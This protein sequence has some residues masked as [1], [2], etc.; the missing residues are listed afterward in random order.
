M[1]D[2]H[3][4][5]QAASIVHD[6]ER[7]APLAFEPLKVV[8]DAGRLPMG[9][10]EDG[11][12]GHGVE[13]SLARHE[14]H[15]RGLHAPAEADDGQSLHCRS[16]SRSNPSGMSR[17]GH[18]RMP[19]EESHV[20]GD[21]QQQEKMDGAGEQALEPPLP[22]PGPTDAEQTGNRPPARQ[23]ASLNRFSR[24]GKSR[25]K[26]NSKGRRTIRCVPTA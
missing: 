6:M 9:V 23:L 2:L 8:V 12:V 26:S 4:L 1:R 3:V 18:I 17:S 22:E 21:G 15:D 5:A 10:G 24:S 20:L 19:V 7:K 16:A 13:G 11:A 14:R 25:G